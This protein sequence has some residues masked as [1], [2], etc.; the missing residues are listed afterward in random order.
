MTVK[1]TPHKVG[2]YDRNFYNLSAQKKYS[3]VKL[4]KARNHAYTP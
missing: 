4:E 1:E 2:P 3:K